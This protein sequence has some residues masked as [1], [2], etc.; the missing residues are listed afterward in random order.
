[1]SAKRFFWYWLAGVS[2][3]LVF[4]AIV[5]AVVDP[6]AIYGWLDATNF[7]TNKTQATDE[8]R[9]TKP[10][11]VERSHPTTLLLGSSRVEVGF[12][13]K[14]SYWPSSMRPVFNLAIPASG[15][16]EQL[17]ILQHALVTTRPKYVVIGISFE[18]AHVPPTNRLL[19]V[20]PPDVTQ[21]GEQFYARLRVTEDGRAN[22]RRTLA[23][24]RD[25]ATSL[26]SIDALEDSILT[27]LRQ[28]DASRSR[29]TSLG[30]NT[31]DSFH[32]LV[33]SDGVYD[34]FVDKDRT[35]VTEIIQ[36]S[37]Q[38]RL[39][40]DEVAKM[41]ELALRH[42]IAVVVIIAPVNAD[43]LEIYNQAGVM[44]L[45]DDWRRQITNIV[46]IAAR[47]GAVSLWDFTGISPYTTESVP[48]PG[49][50]AT[51]LH[52]FWETNHFNRPWATV[53]S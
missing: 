9:L 48:P 44:D 5:N 41:I 17:A 51:Q 35:K 46:A 32:N 39:Q 53:L 29:L 26:L 6:Y 43:E 10:Y 7:N 40:I 3:M 1:M 28:R 25:I 36:W 2:T 15:P 34:L 27:V 52:W 24:A 19:A 8:S 13:P 42:N 16:P 38:P 11:L 49:D 14:S 23:Q 45:Y 22:T 33:L 30:F 50:K 21:A 4:V 31:A 47:E 18:D 12:D 37:A 20:A